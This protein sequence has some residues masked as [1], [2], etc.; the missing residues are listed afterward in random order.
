MPYIKQTLRDKLD[1]DIDELCSNVFIDYKDDEI[2]GIANYVISRYLNSLF[3]KK[4]GL[5]YFTINRMVGVLECVKLEL[6]RRLAS[7]YED[8]CI[9]KNGDIIEYKGI[10]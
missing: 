3:N 7:P 6:Y 10:L 2:E 5:R 1:H 8:N 4:Y 9:N